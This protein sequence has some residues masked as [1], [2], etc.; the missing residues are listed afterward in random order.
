MNFLL[1]L[2]KY[3][4]LAEK[5]THVSVALFSATRDNPYHHRIAFND[6]Y[7][8]DDFLANVSTITFPGYGTTASTRALDRSLSDMFQASNGMRDNAPLTLIFLTD[9]QCNAGGC[10][11]DEFKRLKRVFFGRSIKVIGIGVGLPDNHPGMDEI[12]LLTD[13]RRSTNDFA[14]L[15]SPDFALKLELCQGSH[16]CVLYTSSSKI[17]LF[18]LGRYNALNIHSYFS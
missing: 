6:F 2:G 8:F 1:V 9:G 13:H 7:V 15:Y 14:Q 11:D 17:L 3:M 5:Q 12:G 10:L 16:T 4:G 18:A